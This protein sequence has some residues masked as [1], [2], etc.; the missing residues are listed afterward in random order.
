[1]TGNKVEQRFRCVDRNTGNCPFYK[2]VAT[3]EELIDYLIGKRPWVTKL[4]RFLEWIEPVVTFIFA[5]ALVGLTI[6]GG[7][8]LLDG[9]P[10]EWKFFLLNGR[11]L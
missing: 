9:L 10:F 7:V 1:V 3:D 2:R 6:A 4:G 5:A 11:S 8:V